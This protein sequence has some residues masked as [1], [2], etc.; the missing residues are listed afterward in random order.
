VSAFERLNAALRY[1]IV[2]TLGWTSLR[3]IQLD[4]IEP[5]LAGENV[6]LLAPTAGGKT[7][8][9]LFPVIS[10]LLDG[11]WHGLS[12]LYVCP[13][14]ALLNNLEP[15]VQLYANM[16]GRRAAVW[17]GDVS[18]AARRQIVREPPDL[19]LT[20]PESI[21]AMLISPRIEHRPLFAG[22][23]V[24]IVDELHAFAGDD[25]GWHL[26]ALLERLEH[27]CQRPLQRIGLSA[28]VGNPEMLMTWLGRGRAARVVGSAQTTVEAEVTV[29]FVGSLENA[30]TI[31]S[32]LHRGER[33]L[34][35]CDSRARVESL[36]TSLREAGV[37]TFVSHSSLSLDERRRAEAAFAAEPD[38]IIVATSTLELGLDVGDLDRVVQIDAPSTVSSFLQRMGRTGR[39]PGTRR[40]CLMLATNTEAL[41]IALGIGKLWSQRFVEAIQPPPRPAHIFAQQVMGLTLQQGGIARG[42]WVWLEDVFKDVDR[43]TAA[44]IIDH[45]L[46]TGLLAEDNGVLGLGS[47]AEAKFGRRH[48]QE[49]VAAFTTPLLLAVRYGGKELG[50]IDPQNLNGRRDASPAILLGGRSWRVL[51]VDW[52]RRTVNVEPTAEVGRSRWFGSSRALHAEAARAVEQVLAGSDPGVSL[53]TRAQL[54]L[55]GLRED[56]P[57]LADD[58]LPIVTTGG[59]TRIWTFAGGRANAMLSTP[60]QGAGASLRTLD[61]FGITLRDADKTT[62]AAAFD[63]AKEADCQAPVDMRMM[64]ELKF[65]VC[66]PSR[67][68]E[69]VLRAR[70]SDFDG[71]Q[72]CLQRRRKW[73]QIS[74]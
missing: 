66:L 3:Q 73:I 6:L 59:E 16:V 65:G 19:L 17:H 37:R 72:H 50:S 2:S 27:I 13:L 38:C 20:T 21:E 40:N 7:E 35:F 11:H 5:I 53:S 56:M 28:T 23:Q 52:P 62:L 44:A 14:R 63:R 25:R 32:R 46:V 24:A 33:R 8:A 12:V 1:H 49:L 9:G 47:E 41:M 31:L 57:Y 36:A 70:L 4:A 61:N 30:V 64:D 60:L 54:S 74:D 67:L 48:F 18:D 55:Q 45:M 34:V 58:T 69:D 29:D 26:L 43:A 42:D 71:L 39:R 68:A 15:R 22:L 51:E 10:R